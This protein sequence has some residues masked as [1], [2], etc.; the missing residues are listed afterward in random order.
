MP[1]IIT[2]FLMDFYGFDAETAREILA[3]LRDRRSLEILA[4]GYRVA[5]RAETPPNRV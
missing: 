3:E 2:S 1:E 5:P 4:G